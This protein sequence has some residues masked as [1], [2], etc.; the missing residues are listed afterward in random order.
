MISRQLNTKKLQIFL[1]C[2]PLATIFRSLFHYQSSR[3]QINLST[4]ILQSLSCILL[5]PFHILMQSNHLVMQ[6]LHSNLLINIEAS[7]ERYTILLFCCHFTIT[8]LLIV[9]INITVPNEVLSKLSHTLSILRSRTVSEDTD[10]SSW[11]IDLLL[12]KNVR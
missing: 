1:K 6:L 9:K 7:R 5:H 12:G 3:I 10:S 4:N 11:F 2:K 8:T